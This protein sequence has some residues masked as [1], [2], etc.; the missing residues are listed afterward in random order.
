[1]NVIEAVRARRSVRAFLNDPVPAD[2]M[3]SLLL[4]ASRA[5]S[6][7]NL[8]PW[9]VH[10]LTGKPLRNLLDQVARAGLDEKPGYEV[11]PPKLAEPYRTRRYR[12]GE[13]LYATLS[14]ARDDKPARLT[15]LRRNA[16]FFDAPAGLFVFI[17]KA[18]GPP[19]WSDLGM[20]IQTFMLLAVEQGLA[21][22]AQEYWTLHASTVESHLGVP[23][24]HMLF[25]GIALGYPDPEAPINRLTTERAPLSEWCTLHGFDEDLPQALVKDDR[26]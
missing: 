5:P 6:G 4:E 9:H 22:C 20:F 19:Q 24:E 15:Q 16:R 13:D 7:G 3:R 12:V 10:A 18:M 8:Q 11:Y 21:S 23:G 26:A 17:D 1:M 25:C 2:L 14:I